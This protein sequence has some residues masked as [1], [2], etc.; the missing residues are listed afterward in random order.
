VYFAAMDNVVYALDRG[1]GATEWKKGLSYR[2]ATGPVVV[3]K[4]VLVPSYVDTPLPV[5]DARTGAAAGKMTFGGL[6][7]ALPLFAEV[8]SG[9]PV[10]IA[11]TGGLENKWLISM[12]EPSLIPK[13]TVAP[14]TELP[15]EAVALPPPMTPPKH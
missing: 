6:L 2:P 14:L 13:I 15:G 4:F 5:F 11:I 10:A 1:D 12:L 9:T 8:P 7:V 3:G